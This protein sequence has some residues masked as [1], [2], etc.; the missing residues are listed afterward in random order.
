MVYDVVN[1]ALYIDDFFLF[2]IKLPA[3]GLSDDLG[4]LAPRSVDRT[5]A[6]SSFC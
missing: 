1:Q 4:C 3:K 6:D 5:T 2:L